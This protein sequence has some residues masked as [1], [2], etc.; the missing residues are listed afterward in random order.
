MLTED[1]IRETSVD[2]ITGAIVLLAVLVFLSIFFSQ[3]SEKLK[4]ILFVLIVLAVILP[5]AYF[6][7]TTVMLN[8][9]S[10]TGGPVHWHADFKI[11]VCGKEM[12]PPIPKGLSN[13]VGSTVLHEH[14]DRRIH[15][16]GVLTRIQ[17]ASLRNFFRVQGGELS[18]SHF[19][20]PTG[21][22]KGTVTFTN[23]D[24]CDGGEQG[25]WQAYVYKVVGREGEKHVVEQSKL[26]PFADYVLSPHAAVPPGDCIIL[27]FGPEKDSTGAICDFYE[28]QKQEGNLILQS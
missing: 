26:M 22:D 7:I 10:E 23:G 1:V 9:T 14:E 28:I 5:T 17:D 27:E 6:A 24:R 16:E 11:F 20:I 4:T 25:T 19:T 21:E 12:P 8:V 18:N 13:K 2:I 15:V 3:K